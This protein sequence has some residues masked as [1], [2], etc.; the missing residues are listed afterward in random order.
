MWSKLKELLKKWLEKEAGKIESEPEHD[1]PADPVP[2][3]PVTQN[4]DEATHGFSHPAVITHNMAYIKHNSGNVYFTNPRLDW[5]SNELVGECQLSIK[6]DGKWTEPK[7]FDH[8]RA[9]T[10]SRDFKNIYGG[11]Q[12][13]N[14]PAIGTPCAVI[15]ISYD[16]KKRTNAIF[17]DWK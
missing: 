5:S 7:K 15:L 16:K 1:K 10:T 6:Q 8:I 4:Q 13:W 3:P 2:K 17:F 14:A 9:T 11:Y 12:G